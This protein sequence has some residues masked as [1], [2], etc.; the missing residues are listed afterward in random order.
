MSEELQNKSEE[1]ARLSRLESK[2]KDDLKIEIER[3]LRRSYEDERDA[4]VG[5]IKDENI[6]LKKDI[7]KLGSMN[8]QEKIEG[9]RKKYAF[10]RFRLFTTIKR[11]V[12]EQKETG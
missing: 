12:D 11:L 3:D 6:N 8:D 2:H 5:H 10:F 4:A 1:I 9:Y 7:E